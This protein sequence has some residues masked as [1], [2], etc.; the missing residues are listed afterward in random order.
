LLGKWNLLGSLYHLQSTCQRH[1][2]YDIQCQAPFSAVPDWH[3]QQCHK[4]NHFRNN[5]AIKEY[6]IWD[7]NMSGVLTYQSS[8]PFNMTVNNLQLTIKQHQ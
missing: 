1:K 6:N 5:F 3:H 8:L 4:H 7:N 2:Y